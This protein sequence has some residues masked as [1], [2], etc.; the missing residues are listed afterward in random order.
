MKGNARLPPSCRSI[1]HCL[2][3]LAPAMDE[4]TSLPTLQDSQVLP[5]DRGGME[6]VAQGCLWK[7]LEEAAK[8]VDRA[9]EEEQDLGGGEDLGGAGVVVE[10]SLAYPQVRVAR[11]VDQSFDR[12]K[13]RLISMY[14]AECS[15]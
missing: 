11:R 1:G 2:Q 12:L 5:E 15:Y 6:D 13:K 14:L 8:S 10:A 9:L 4:A 3:D 7:V